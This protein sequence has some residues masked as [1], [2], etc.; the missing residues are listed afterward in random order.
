MKD[1][2]AFAFVESDSHVDNS[3]VLEDGIDPNSI[4]AKK[5]IDGKWV[6]APL[7]YFVE[8]ISPEGI[9]EKINS[10]VYSSD[11]AGEIIPQHVGIGWKKENN[12]WVNIKEIEEKQRLEQEKK[13][14]QK[15]I[16]GI[17]NSKPH[18]SWIWVDGNWVAP[19]A[20]P[21]DNPDDYYW[22]EQSVSWRQY[23]DLQEENPQIS[24]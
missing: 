12:E 16:E 3:I 10:T 15:N 8:Q 13:D 20:K 18:P 23:I 4:L 24:Q 14:L 17:L 21:E 6:A 9:I 19:V 1:D 5:I 7:F 2:I 22:D 11:V